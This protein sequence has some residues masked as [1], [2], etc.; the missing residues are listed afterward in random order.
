MAIKMACSTATRAFFGPRRVA[1][2]RSFGQLR[3]LRS[4]RWQPA[5]IGPDNAL[6]HAPTTYEAK[7]DAEGWLANERRLIAAGDWV[8]PDQRSALAASKSHT[9]AEYAAPWLADRT[10]KP[11][12]RDH[13][14]HLLDRLILPGLG[15]KPLRALTPVV[16]RSWHAELGSKTPTLKRTRTDCCAPSSDRRCTTA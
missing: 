2:C 13:Y 8:P 5:Y 9:L 4:G 15:D 1:I 3:R 10:L 12:T 6:H 11:R 14:Q 16:I 7:I